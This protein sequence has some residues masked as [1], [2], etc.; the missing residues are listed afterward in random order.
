MTRKDILEATGMKNGG[1]LTKVLDDLVACGFVRVYRAFGKSQRNRIYQLA[2]AFTLF[3]LRF[4]GKQGGYEENFWMQFC[5]TSAHAAWSGYAFEQLC[6]AHIPQIKRKLGISGVLSMVSS[7][8]SETSDP[9]A[10]VDLVIE[11][12]DKVINLC[13]VKFASGEYAIDKKY[14]MTL[15]NKRQAFLSETGTRKSA[16]TTLITT[17]GLKRNAYQGEILSE[18]VL[19]DLFD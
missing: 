4:S 7:W 10:Q 11:R 13:E 5:T 6:M 3:H 12:E 8:R 2:D 1:R 17:F 18:V 14:S 19:D 9:G 15:R 16:V